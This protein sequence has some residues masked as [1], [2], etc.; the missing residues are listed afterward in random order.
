MNIKPTLTRYF[1]E[2]EGMEFYRK[3]LLRAG[4][5]YDYATKIAEE[6]YKDYLQRKQ[7][8]EKDE[9]IQKD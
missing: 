2:K 3:N 6:R 9:H 5:G 8:E 7:A 4:I 1:I